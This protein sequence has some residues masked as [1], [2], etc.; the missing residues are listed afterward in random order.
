LKLNGPAGAIVIIESPSD[1]IHWT[2]VH[3]NALSVD[4]LSLA[5]P[6]DMNQPGQFFRARFP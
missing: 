3:T 4:G 6:I 2:P 5:V 1:L